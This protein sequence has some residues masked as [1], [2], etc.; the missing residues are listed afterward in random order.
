VNTS[1]TAWYNTTGC[2][3]N[4]T[5]EQERNLTQYDDNYCG[6]VSNTTFYEYRSV[7]CDACTPNLVNTSWT[8][9][10]DVSGCYAN[11]TLD[12]ERNRTQ[13]DD[14]YCGEVSNTTYY[15]Y[16]TITCDYCTPNLVNTS[17][18]AWYDISGCYAHDTLDQERNLTQYDDNYCGE[19]SNT[20]YYEQ[21]TAACDYCAPNWQA[22]NTSC[23]GTHIVQYYLDDDNCYAQTGLASDLAGKPA[24]QTYPC[25]TGECSSDSD[26]GT[27][28]WLGNE[29]C[30]GDDVWDDYRTWACN[31]P[32]TPS[33]ACSYN[34]NSQ[35][36]E[37]CT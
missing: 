1:W 16:Q 9:W 17:W 33:S 6:E 7:S 12:Q 14:N 34:D 18:T 27:D 10:Y 36:K 20:T 4:D 31:N 26:C 28:G 37:T 3:A 29:Y 25:G 32:G 23:N 21:Q 13:Y 22:Y 11:D 35:L 8:V 15:E 2:L 5:V 19:I 30:S 24:N